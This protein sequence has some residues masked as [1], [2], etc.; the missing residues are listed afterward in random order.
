MDK[1]LSFTLLLIVIGQL[2]SYG[3]G[4]IKVNIPTAKDEA[5]YIW[6]TI[7]DIKFFEQHKYP[8]S[9]PK[10]ALIEALKKKAR[11][12]Q[13]SEQDYAAIEQ[14]M[15]NKVYRKSAYTKGIQ[16][17]EK[18]LTL[19]NRLVERLGKNKFN[20][21]FKEYDTYQVNL[22]LYG[23]GGSYDA[24]RGII[25]IF[26]TPEGK[27]KQYKNPVNT[28][29]H[30]IVH[31]GMEA[32]IMR[33]Y[34]VDHGLKE[35]IIDTFVMHHFKKYLPEYRIQNM[36]DKRLDAYLSKKEDFR[37]LEKIIQKMSGK[38]EK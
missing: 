25:T 12:N 8:V 17:I 29:I 21:P 16:M 10:D 9:L 26:T 31:I 13:F 11:N 2:N 5:A 20:W 4:K 37:N 32:S 38:K 30:E 35:R 14:L 7:R 3:Q 23:S 18:D 27:F 1:R 15:R 28:L 34:K 33:K 19:L 24:D 6:R 36:G 22:T